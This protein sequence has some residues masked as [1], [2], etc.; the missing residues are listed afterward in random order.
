M[1]FLNGSPDFLVKSPMQFTALS[2]I[3]LPVLLFKGTVAK[4]K[5][6]TMKGIVHVLTNSVKREHIGGE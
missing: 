6:Y 5:R 1:N 4:I 2:T 3:P